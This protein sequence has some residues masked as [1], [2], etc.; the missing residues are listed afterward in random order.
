MH[1]A[2]RRQFLANLSAFGIA[3]L[4]GAGSN[5]TDGVVHDGDSAVPH[6]MVDLARVT[7]AEFAVCLGSAFRIYR[8]SGDPI[9]V[10]LVRAR[11]VRR[12]CAARGEPRNPFTLIFRGDGTDVLPQETYRLEHPR[13]GAFPLFIVPVGGP[14]N[15]VRYQAVFA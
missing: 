11:E 13:L 8:T 7:C 6:G 2:S 10:E 3:G 5:R 9:E 14:G 15:I 4:V 12:A 1:S